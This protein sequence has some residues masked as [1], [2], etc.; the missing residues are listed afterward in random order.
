MASGQV[1][2][3]AFGKTWTDA[4]GDSAFRPTGSPGS[5]H[6][7]Q[8]SFDLQSVQVRFWQPASASDPFI[9]V[10]ALQS[11]A[12]AFRVDIRIAGLVA[13]P[14]PLGLG[15]YPW[16]PD[17]FGLNPIYG[18]IEFDVDGRKNS[19]GELEPIAR[20]R[21]LANVARFG[22]LPESS[23]G[24]RAAQSA[25]DYDGEFF[26]GPQ[27][28]RTGAEFAIAL[29][30]CFNPTVTLEVGDQDEIF[31]AGEIMDVRGR[32][33]ERTQAIASFAGAF[34]GSDFGLYDPEV[35]LRFEHDVND[36]VT[37]ISFVYALDQNGAAL[38]ADEPVQPLDLNVLNHTSL[39]EALNDLIF[40]AG[41]LFGPITDP[42]VVELVEDWDDRPISDGLDVREWDALALIGTAYVQ[43]S[44]GLFVWSDVGFDSSFGD[45]NTDGLIDALDVTAVENAIAILDGGPLDDDGAANGTVVIQE[46]G[47]N[48]N[49]HDINSDGLINTADA[50]A[51]P[52]SGPNGD[53]NG[54]GVVNGADLAALLAQWG[55]N[56]SA[57]LNQDGVVDGADLATLLANWT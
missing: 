3:D 18:F 47:S 46:F 53:L 21:Y 44:G 42:A 36:D 16:D 30:G 34:G 33:F 22:G 15:G 14:G 20:Q 55:S 2:T 49:L 7:D 25:A 48:F 11:E 50:D 19:G 4:A 32:F 56:S 17:R 5:P 45:M 35:V 10:E 52:L 28:E 31:D 51:I 39:S 1:S 57:D 9:G 38:L 29:C 24:E 41:G 6:F 23:F 26:T 12:H 54:D 27:F 8:S 40:T 13:P 43:Q 37:T